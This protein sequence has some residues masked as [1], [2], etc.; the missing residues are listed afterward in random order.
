MFYQIIELLH[1]GYLELTTMKELTTFIDIIDY[2][3]E[4]SL[5]EFIQ[6]CINK[7]IQKYEIFCLLQLAYR[8]GLQRTFTTCIHYLEFD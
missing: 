1:G 3:R 4:R 6:D 8:Y 2:L 5:H 7:D